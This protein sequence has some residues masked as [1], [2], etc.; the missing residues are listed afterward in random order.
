MQLICLIV[1]ILVPAVIELSLLENVFYFILLP[2]LPSAICYMLNWK[3]KITFNLGLFHN[4]S[5][6]F[7]HNDSSKFSTTVR[8]RSAPP[9][10]NRML[11]RFPFKAVTQALRM[12]FKRFSQVCGC[13]LRPRPLTI[14]GSQAFRISLKRISEK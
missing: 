4:D 14:C 13:A 2:K 1:I 9:A 3:T 12:W 5:S 6:K 10:L 7:S 11:K 8:V